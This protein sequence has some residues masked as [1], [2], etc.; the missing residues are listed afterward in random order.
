MHANYCT[1]PG[2][3]PAGP[4]DLKCT[5]SGNGLLPRHG[6]YIVCVRYSTYPG[7]GP[8]GSEHLN[9]T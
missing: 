3:S 9:C 5:Y 4:E 2:K 1:Y 8:E 6:T 7:E